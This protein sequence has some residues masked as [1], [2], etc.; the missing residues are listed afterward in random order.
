MPCSAGRIHTGR[1][2][3]SRPGTATCS[4]IA[5]AVQAATGQRRSPWSGAAR[6]AAPR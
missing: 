6:P 4:P 5:T 2:T 1:S 3:A